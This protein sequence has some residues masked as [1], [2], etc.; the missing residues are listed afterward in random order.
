MIL[1]FRH[2]GIVVDDLDR[3]LAFYVDKLGFKVVNQMDECGPYIDFLLQMSNA[4]VTTVKLAAP[5]G[6]MIEL[7]KFNRP[8]GPIRR[9]EIFEHCLS[10]IA[11]TV[12]DVMGMYEKLMDEG[13]SFKAPPL[14]SPDGKHRVTFMLDPDGTYLELVE[15]LH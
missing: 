8:M 12:D 6:S 14:L 2:A 11:L 1:G 13:V 15:I 5:D 9:H 7:L 3:S 10:H 4:R